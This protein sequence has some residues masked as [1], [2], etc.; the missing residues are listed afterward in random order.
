MDS[1]EWRKISTRDRDLIRHFQ[2]TIPVRLS[3][4][5]HKLGLKVVASTLPPGISGEIRPSPSGFTISVNRHDSSKRQRFTVAH[6]IAHYLLHRDQ[7]GKGITDDALY[8]SSLS[9]WREAE[10]NRLAA[11]IILPREAL[12]LRMHSTQ[13]IG[14]AELV[15]ELATQFNVSDVA[16]KIRLGLS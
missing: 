13:G 8:R 10:A 12:E 3:S 14:E 5:A 6:E 11:D 9:D 7:I 4:L 1:K 2:E 16:M 15:S